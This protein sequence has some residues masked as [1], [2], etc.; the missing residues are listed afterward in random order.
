MHVPTNTER[1]DFKFLSVLSVHRISG[2]GNA[3]P[4]NPDLVNR[5]LLFSHWTEEA[6]EIFD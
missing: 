3:Q 2:S 6:D 5:N 4:Q 1:E